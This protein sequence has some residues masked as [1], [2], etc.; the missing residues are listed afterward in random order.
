M[1]RD[2][3]IRCLNI[4]RDHYNQKNYEQALKFFQKSYKLEKSDDALNMMTKCGEAIRN[5]QG[6]ETNGNHQQSQ[7]NRSRTENGSS[8]RSEPT[9][10]DTT[11]R[12]EAIKNI[13]KTKDFYE[14]L[15][16]TKTSTEDEIKKSYKKLALKFHP[17]K[18]KEVGADE[19]FKKIAQAYDCLTDPE[20]KRK[21][22]E[23]GT[24]EP[25][26]HYQHY[27][28]HY[29]EDISADDIFGMFFGNGFAQGGPRRRYQQRPPQ[30][31]YQEEP[32]GGRRGNTGTK[33]LPLL[34]FLPILIIIISTFAFGSSHEDPVFSLT[35][36]YKY[37]IE[38]KTPN[39]KLAYYVE[40]SFQG[41]YGSNRSKLNQLERGIEINYL[42]Q[43][44][45][46]CNTAK[47]KVQN[48][49]RQAAYYSGYDKEKYLQYAKQVD[50][51]ACYKLKEYREKFPHLFY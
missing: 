3:A 50:M 40:S 41:D 23:Y 49:E 35:P 7:Q 31:H 33:N 2:E 27:R 25:E 20:K 15:G 34:Q 48:F 42:Q 19:A 5:A 36:T 22:D 16:V 43:M 44:E 12:N 13:M 38:R 28:Q 17:D 26:Q 11:I 21:Y 29:S 18:N 1:N 39:L 6:A 46:N 9:K 4:A 51:S 45:S 14:I 8:A 30:Q 10:K 47:R 24:E 37:N 32:R